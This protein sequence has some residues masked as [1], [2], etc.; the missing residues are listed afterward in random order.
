MTEGGREKGRGRRRGGG[1]KENGRTSEGHRS[2]QAWAVSSTAPGLLATSPGRDAA[3]GLGAVWT[4]GS[5]KSS[6]PW[7]EAPCS[8]GPCIYPAWGPTAAQKDRPG[9]LPAGTETRLCTLCS[10]QALSHGTH[11]PFGSSSV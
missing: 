6:L 2:S 3:A 4:A 8:P 1:R 9:E 10:A 5:T 11:L 7:S